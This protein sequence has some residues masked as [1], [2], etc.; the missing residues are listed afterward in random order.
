MEF[1]KELVLGLV[2]GINW[3]ENKGF[4]PPTIINKVKT[5]PRGQNLQ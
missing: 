4:F 5:G 1:S 3:T 2:T